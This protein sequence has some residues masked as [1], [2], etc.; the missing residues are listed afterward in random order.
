MA[1]KIAF[2]CLITV[3]AMCAV[4]SGF[5]K[6]AASPLTNKDFIL[7]VTEAGQWKPTDAQAAVAKAALLSYLSSEDHPRSPP[8]KYFESMRPGIQAG[9]GSYS[10]QYF[11][12]FYN[13]QNGGWD[14]S[15]EKEILIN[16]LCDSFVSHEHV[17]LSKELQSVQD[18][19]P[20]FF[21]AGYSLSQH[22][23]VH[24][25]VNGPPRAP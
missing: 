9:I 8:E 11:G 6:A 1:F 13:W 17:N 3:I 24:F 20:C 23:I 15:G 18:G 5:L 10:L 19:G 16:A 4:G 7:D 12:G 14:P 25:S 21:Q 22:T 2:A